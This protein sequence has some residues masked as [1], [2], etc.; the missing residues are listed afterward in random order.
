M[1]SPISPLSSALPSHPGLDRTSPEGRSCRD[2]DPDDGACLDGDEQSAEEG[3]TMGR[4]NNDRCLEE[5]TSLSSHFNFQTPTS[6]LSQNQNSYQEDK[7]GEMFGEIGLRFIDSSAVE[8][9]I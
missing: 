7:T 6:H 3:Q 8:E 5:V 2:I 4:E 1:S 9:D